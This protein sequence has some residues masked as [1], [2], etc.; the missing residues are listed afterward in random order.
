M[1]SK[2]NAVTPVKS[3]YAGEP[4]LLDIP[5]A[6]TSSGAGSLHRS[7][8][9]RLSAT[10]GPAA[11]MT[12][13][14]FTVMASLIATDFQPV[15]AAESRTIESI[16]PEKIDELEVKPRPK[17]ELFETVAAPPP[18]PKY[19]ISKDIVDLPTPVFTGEAPTDFSPG[20]IE[21]LETVPVVIL[22]TDATPLRPPVV[23]YPSTALARGITGE[24]QVVFDVDRQGKPFNIVPDCSDDVFSRAAKKAISRVEFAPKIQEGRARERKNVVYPI[25]FSLT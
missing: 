23:S 5:F 17:V 20:P 9:L 8:K 3:E 13:G 11:L 22:D 24:C 6:R 19:T 18:P 1:S 25:V 2:I 21:K 4:K 14:L 15:E 16:V 12:L 10:L 7:S